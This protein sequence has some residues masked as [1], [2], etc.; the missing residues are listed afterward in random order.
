MQE[1]ISTK[2]TTAHVPAKS[3]PYGHQRNTMVRSSFASAS[4][5]TN[6]GVNAPNPLST[7]DD[8]TDDAGDDEDEDPVL[9][10]Y[11]IDN[12]FCL[13]FILATTLGGYIISFLF[14]DIFTLIVILGK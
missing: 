14:I 12:F 9:I 6:L 7:L 11:F 3:S 13:I 8:P 5:R 1:S 2:V 4:I 10:R